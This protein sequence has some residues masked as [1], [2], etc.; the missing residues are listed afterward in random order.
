[1]LTPFKYYTV[2]IKNS[3]QSVPDN[4]ATEAEA[5]ACGVTYN[6]DF[7]VYNFGIAVGYYIDKQY[8]ALDEYYNRGG[9]PAAKP[10]ID[11]VAV[12]GYN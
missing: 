5:I 7:I 6:A 8:L 2:Y 1:M 11:K 10:S 3:K 9:I 4:F 12:L